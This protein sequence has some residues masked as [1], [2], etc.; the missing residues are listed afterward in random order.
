MPHVNNASARLEAFAE[1]GLLDPTAAKVLFSALTTAFSLYRQQKGDKRQRQ[2]M[3]EIERSLTT[4]E[5]K[6]DEIVHLIHKMGLTLMK[7]LTASR[8][9]GMRAELE[10]WLDVYREH[11]TDIAD[12]LFG[13]TLLSF[14][15]HFQQRTRA[16]MLAGGAN[17]G[18]VAASM[19]A[20]HDLLTMAASDANEQWKPSSD[21]IRN[22]I[23]RYRRYFTRTLDDANR[24]NKSYRDTLTRH[25]VWLTNKTHDREWFHVTA[26]GRCGYQCTHS[27]DVY[28][29][30]RGTVDAG[31]R[32]HSEQRNYSKVINKDID[33]EI[34]DSD[35]YHEVAESLFR[36]LTLA[37]SG[38]PIVDGQ[39]MNDAAAKARD[40]AGEWN[41][42]ITTISK[43][44]A[45]LS[46]LQR[47]SRVLE[48]SIAM[49]DDLMG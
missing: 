7:E 29:I 13:D 6:L 31:F 25:G 39:A 37:E 26:R 36:Q 20:E 22:S 4:L 42:W 16:Y 14:V 2:W 24:R 5:G 45:R 30:I 11:R 49:C 1:T 41:G 40:R 38:D 10:A 43:T 47:V 15:V 18:L 19:L 32:G 17:F 3:S 34:D 33:R 21:T 12:G 48:E 35:V 44:T 46:D 28:S 8:I 27:A 23:T 9:E